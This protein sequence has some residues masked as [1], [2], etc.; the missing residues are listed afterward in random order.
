[1]GDFDVDVALIK[2]DKVL[3]VKQSF[4]RPPLSLTQV[5]LEGYLSYQQ[6]NVTL[7]FYATDSKPCSPTQV[8]SREIYLCDPESQ[9]QLGSVSFASAATQRFEFSNPQLTRGI[10]SGNLWLG[11]RQEN[12]LFSSG[13]LRFRNLTVTATARV[14]P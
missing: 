10:N 7:G 9:A 3:Y 6:Q 2:S 11:V 1:L 4:E 12:G 13:T 5:V 14:A 8:G